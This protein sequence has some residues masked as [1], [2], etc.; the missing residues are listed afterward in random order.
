MPVDN[1]RM[2][3][4]E[5]LVSAIVDNGLEYSVFV[6]INEDENYLVFGSFSVAEAFSKFLDRSNSL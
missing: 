2:A 6:G 4:R 3:P 5:E 1:E